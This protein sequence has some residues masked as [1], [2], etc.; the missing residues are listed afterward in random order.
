MPRKSF[1]ELTRRNIRRLIDHA[2]KHLEL[3]DLDKVYV[4]NELLNFF[5]VSEPYNDDIGEYELYTVLDELFDMAVKKKLY[6]PTDRLLFEGRIM[7][8]L[9]PRPMSVVERFDNIAAYEGSRA[10]AKWLQSIEENSTY[11]RRPDLDKN[12]KWEHENKDRGNVVVTI[13]LAKPEK[14]AEEVARAKNAKTGYPKCVLCPENIGHYGNA[15]QPARQ[16]IRI[17]P[18]E[19]NGENWYMQ[20]SPYE[21]FPEHIIAI[22]GDHRPMKITGDTF[23]RMVDFVDLFP[24]YFIG[25]NAALPIVGGSV[26]AHDHYQGGSKA[27]PIFDRSARKHYLT[28]EFADCNVSIVDWYNSVIR[29]ESKNKK[30]VAELAEKF[31]S[32]WDEYSDESVEVIAKTTDVHN[33]VTPIAYINSDGEYT[34]MLILRNNRTDNERPDGIFH[35]TK[36]M[37]NIKQESIGIIEAMGLFILPGRLATETMA[38]KDLLT[39]VTPLDFKAIADESHHL[40]KHLGMI[41]QLTA[42]NGTSMKDEKAGDVITDYINE[43]CEKILDCTAVFKSDEKGQ[44]AFDKF[45]K[46]VIG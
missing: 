46:S 41:A 37:H 1:E 45:I 18:L 32:A 3:A 4:E 43:T 16:H 2:E 7:G 12:I 8:T 24:E 22:S 19:L 5:S 23:K 40:H 20:F 29:I 33:A 27:L 42:T 36:D 26:L 15:G 9:M 25:S 39:G 34:V 13:N 10:A 6:E 31:R 14:T 28:S 21:Y 44:E 11:L 30:Q 38:I 17:I 35:P